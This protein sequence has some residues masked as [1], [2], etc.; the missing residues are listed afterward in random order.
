MKI[1][2]LNLIVLL[3][4]LFSS[5]GAWGQTAT[6]TA[7]NPV[8]CKATLTGVN[9]AP[10]VNNV[11]ATVV[12]ISSDE[13]DKYTWEEKTF[14]KLANNQSYVNL[15]RT[16][17]DFH[18]G[19]K[20]KV[21]VGTIDNNRVVSFKLNAGTSDSEFNARPN[22]NETQI[23][24]TYTVIE[25]SL[26]SDDINDDGSI[27]I[28]RAGG[29]GYA[30]KYYEF[31][32]ECDPFFGNKELSNNTDIV[33]IKLGNGDWEYANVTYPGIKSTAVELTDDIPSSGTYLI[34]KPSKQIN[35]KLKTGSANNYTTHLIDADN[36]TVN[37]GYNRPRYS[38]EISFNSLKAGK[39]YY[40]YGDGF[41]DAGDY[42]RI[43]SFTALI[44]DPKI[45]FSAP[46]VFDWADPNDTQRTGVTSM[47]TAYN[48][49][50]DKVIDNGDYVSE[51]DEIEITAYQYSDNKTQVNGDATINKGRLVLYNWDINGEEDHTNIPSTGIVWYDNTS[52]YTFT[53]TRDTDIKAIYNLS[54]VIGFPSTV[55]GGSM[56]ANNG[57]TPLSSNISGMKADTQITLTATPDD[58]YS[59]DHWKGELYGLGTD[60]VWTDENWSTDPNFTFTI[61][62]ANTFDYANGYDIKVT[63][64]FREAT[65]E[66][67]K[68]AE[69]ITKTSATEYNINIKQH[70]AELS[71]TSNEPVFNVTVAKE[72]TPTTGVN[73]TSHLN[74]EITSD[75]VKI[76]S[77]TDADGGAVIVNVKVGDKDLGNYVIT[78]PYI[79][80]HTWDFH[81]M[82][83]KSEQKTT[84]NYKL[85]YEVIEGNRHKDP[86]TV[87]QAQ[88]KEDNAAII[89]ATNGL[90]ITNNNKRNTGLSAIGP[91]G[92]TTTPQDLTSVTDVWLVTLKNSTLT[93][94]QQKKD[95]FIKI[96]LL[97]H[98]G[99]TQSS[100]AGTEFTVNNLSD[101]NGKAINPTHTLVTN[102]VR[103]ESNVIEYIH[104][105]NNINGCM[106]FR[107]SED[108]DVKFNFSNN[109]WNKIVKI[110]VTDTYSTELM[111]G[112]DNEN[113]LVDYR[114]FNHSWVYREYDSSYGKPNTD[115]GIYYNG[116]P[117]VNG[118]NAYWI[119]HSISKY[120]TP[121]TGNQIQGSLSNITIEESSWTSTGG[122]NYQ[123]VN[124]HG[125]EGVGNVKIISNAYYSGKIHNNG[126]ETQDRYVLN[127]NETWVAVGKLKVQKYPYTWDFTSY[128]MDATNDKTVDKISANVTGIPADT[129]YGSWNGKCHNR[130]VK[131]PGTPHETSPYYH[132]D[133]D[134][135]KTYNVPIYKP[136]FAS[137]SQLTIGTEAIKETEGLGIYI[138]QAPITV[139]SNGAV[140]E[141]GEQLTLDGNAMS[142]NHRSTLTIRIPEVPSSMYIFINSN[143]KPTSVTNSTECSEITCK[144]NV[145]CYKPTSDGDVLINL[146]ARSVIYRI[147]VTDQIKT[148]SNFGYSTESRA[149]DIDYNETPNFSANTA[150]YYVTSVNGWKTNN[151]VS[152]VGQI[153][154]VA[155]DEYVPAGTGIILQDK[156]CTW[157]KEDG[158][159]GTRIKVP[160][161]VPAVNINRTEVPEGNL[162]IA[163][164]TADQANC[165]IY[166]SLVSAKEKYYVMQSYYY[167]V[168]DADNAHIGD[169]V[170]TDKPGFYRYIGTDG[171]TMTNMAYLYFNESSEAAVKYL[172]DFIT[173]DFDNAETAIES[174]KATSDVIENEKDVYYNINGQ[175]ILKPATRGI[176]IKNGKKIY[177][178]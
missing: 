8:T 53:A 2:S 72:T 175:Q 157:K 42:V 160:L 11:V 107:V 90:T 158:A 87:Y 97:P 57:S 98:A 33:S 74:A 126:W 65:I 94:P 170:Y 140:N 9:T 111:L 49:T 3:L 41:K 142:I 95:W 143:N 88:I 103:R 151:A 100:G 124:I 76:I 135:K 19:D 154:E 6:W 167:N 67:T 77:N 159:N 102:G 26:K 30:C 125:N 164:T 173:L 51:G 69:T 55:T 128:N 45:T 146:P 13:S 83:N 110:V 78:V 116:G 18:A 36:P 105:N 120:T 82:E 141:N 84:G 23:S 54:Y 44:V 148:I 104:N 12:G 127:T 149:I 28:Y 122:V 66:L 39:T 17:G 163:S 168:E 131:V 96:Y 62:G 59:F 79:G 114:R 4:C 7:T 169:K 48:K 20:L 10:T 134:G 56:T 93:L 1:K 166:S 132:I 156:D 92:N 89:D 113:R 145:Y 34:I 178:K 60:P 73:A 14:Y 70:I 75:G 136:L 161:F 153:Q 86:M 138:N 155:T 37:L 101:L 64:I 118:E 147:G 50:Q 85:E 165:P 71:T 121:E 117:W 16:S 99:G 115:A 43:Q 81:R 68:T 137:G 106:I 130:L 162:L 47:V 63:P 123:G 129:L 38:Q 119:D 176:Y 152:T 25:Y 58:G 32:V 112:G 46:K 177:V 22:I 40:F 5:I 21:T 171:A 139:S 91:D 144:D 80:N 15:K 27:S 52:K 31:S 61:D 29:T 24:N 109:G 133:N 108:G 174:I 172:S 35:L 150:A